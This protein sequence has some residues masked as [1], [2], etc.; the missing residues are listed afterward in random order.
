MVF[1]SFFYIAFRSSRLKGMLRSNTTESVRR[2]VSMN[3]LRYARQLVLPIELEPLM[4]RI[5]F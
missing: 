1:L 4:T 3:F 5:L 2:F